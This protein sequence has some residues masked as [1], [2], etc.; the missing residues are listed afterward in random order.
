MYTVYI[1]WQEKGEDETILLRYPGVAGY[2]PGYSLVIFP[3][4]HNNGYMLRHMTH[5]HSPVCLSM[6]S[7]GCCS[8]RINPV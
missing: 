2:S 5:C 6:M 3:V 7:L 1:R 4:E 8:S